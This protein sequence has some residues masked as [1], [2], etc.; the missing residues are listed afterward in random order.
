MQQQGQDAGVSPPRLDGW[1]DEVEAGYVVRQAGFFSPVLCFGQDDDF[2]IGYVGY[3]VGVSSA[4]ETISEIPMISALGYATSHSFT[5]LKPH[6]FEREDAR[7]NE[8]AMEVLFCGVCHSDIHQAKNEWGN[9]VYPCMPGHE[10]VG[11]V[12][13]I[14]SDVTR[15][16]VGMW[17]VSGT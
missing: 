8:V 7:P 3:V 2:G 15:H 16:K 14:G 5:G 13:A 4:I 17:W 11:R 10:V 1:G 9:T 12:T 6:S